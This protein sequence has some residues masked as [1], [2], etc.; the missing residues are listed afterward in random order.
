M[1]S[2][3]LDYFFFRKSL[4][5][6]LTGLLLLALNQSLIGCAVSKADQCKQLILIT[7]QMREQG[8][9]YKDT[10]EAE[11]VLKIADAFEKTADK[12][13]RLKLE[14]PI[15]VD[16]QGE[17]EN[18]YRGNAEATR[19]MVKALEGKDILTAQLAQQQVQT[20]GKQEQQVVTNINIHCQNP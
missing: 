4:R 8:A 10:T 14:D 3:I 2:P 19:N 5:F 15:L 13:E 9:E 20:L 16:Y 1:R 11:G 17:L 6:G 18:I 7:K 12:V